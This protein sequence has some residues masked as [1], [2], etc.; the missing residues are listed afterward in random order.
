[1]KLPQDKSLLWLKVY[2]MG[3]SAKVLDLVNGR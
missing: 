2:E 1:M 3:F